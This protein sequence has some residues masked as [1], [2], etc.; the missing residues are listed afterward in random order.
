MSSLRRGSTIPESEQDRDYWK[1]RYERLS[2][3][4]ESALQEIR[5]LSD[6]LGFYASNWDAWGRIAKRALGN[7]GSK[8]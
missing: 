8:S 6:A 2:D 3:E 4:H 7:N 1:R 5:R